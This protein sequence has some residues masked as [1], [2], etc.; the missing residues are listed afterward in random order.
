MCGWVIVYWDRANVWN[1]LWLEKKNSIS[2]IMAFGNSNLLPSQPAGRNSTWSC[3]GIKQLLGEGYRLG[4][5]MC[6]IYF[7]SEWGQPQRNKI[8]YQRPNTICPE[9][10][11]I[12]PRSTIERG[13]TSD[14]TNS[15]STGTVQYTTMQCTVYSVH[16]CTVYKTVHGLPQNQLGK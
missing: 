4:G 10:S 2:K 15:A 9:P 3:A 7:G 12:Q 13:P 16:H 1:S 5:G 14:V 11:G 6:C 8:T